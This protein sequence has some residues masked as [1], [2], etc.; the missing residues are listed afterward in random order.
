MSI[1]TYAVPTDLTVAPWSLTLTD[2]A[3]TR[4]LY[5]ASILIRRATKTAIYTADPLTGLPTDDTLL[6]AFKDA[7]CAQVDACSQLDIDPAAGAGKAATVVTQKSH[8]GAS[9]QYAA[10][11]STVEARAQAAKHISPN[12][13]E[14]LRDGGLVGGSP[15]VS[16]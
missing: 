7:T 9:I 10:Y 11:A 3:A 1:P 13:L 15:L 6:A 14:I 8:G 12:A 2:T 16:G 4:L 5:Y